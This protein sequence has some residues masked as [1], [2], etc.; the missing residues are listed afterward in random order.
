MQRIMLDAVRSSLAVFAVKN[1]T[2]PI[3]SSGALLGTL[4]LSGETAAELVAAQAAEKL[5]RCPF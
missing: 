3:G 1:S 5:F 4:S 2:R